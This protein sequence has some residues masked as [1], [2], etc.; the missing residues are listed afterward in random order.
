M[1]LTKK[2]LVS[3]IAKNKWLKYRR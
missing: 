2:A 1:H 3:N